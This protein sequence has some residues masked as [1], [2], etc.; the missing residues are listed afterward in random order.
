MCHCL[1]IHK[2]KVFLVPLRYILELLDDCD[3]DKADCFA[4]GSLKRENLGPLGKL[5]PRS[6]KSK[7]ARLANV[8]YLAH[9]LWGL[10]P[11]GD[12]SSW[13]SSSKEMQS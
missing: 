2:R 3:A 4:W 13:A 11:Q 12:H 7:R 5:L 10:I 6:I 9:Q 1:L 8:L